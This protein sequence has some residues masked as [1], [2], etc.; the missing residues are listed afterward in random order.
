MLSSSLLYLSLLLA[1]EL[2][3]SAASV[4]ISM[5][6]AMQIQP[7]QCNAAMISPQTAFAVAKPKAQLTKDYYRPPTTY[8]VRIYR[9]YLPFPAEAL[10]QRRTEKASTFHRRSWVTIS[11]RLQ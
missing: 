2:V 6:H 9:L 8:E 10:L 4:P 5:R 1:K 7:P 11:R 3:V